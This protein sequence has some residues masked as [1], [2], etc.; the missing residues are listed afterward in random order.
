MEH[1]SKKRIFNKNVAEFLKNNGAVYLGEIIGQVPE[2]PDI[3][4]FFFK[5][6]ER[7]FKALDLYHAVK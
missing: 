2:R 7:L 6:D 3:I 1:V 4:T 5:K